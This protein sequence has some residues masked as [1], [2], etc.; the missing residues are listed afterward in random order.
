MN[1]ENQ[2]PFKAIIIGGGASGLM[3]SINLANKFGGDRIL[4]L[5]K[6]D[7][8]GKKLLSTGNGRCNLSNVD[9]DYN[10]Y[11]SQNDGYFNQ[12]IA[13][14]S[15]KV[16][17]F[18]NSI[19]V[20][21]SVEDGKVFPLSKQASSVLDAMRFKLESIGVKTLTSTSVNR[22]KKYDKIFTVFDENGREFYGENVI[23]SVGGKCQ[24]H[25]GTDGSSYSLL[26]EF[27]HKLT[28][29]YPSIVQLKVKDLLRIKGLKGLKQ[30]VDAKAVV[31]GKVV[32]KTQGDLLFTDYGL[33]GNVAFYLS[34]YLTGIKGGVIEIDFCP[35]L[36]REE[37]TRLLIEKQ[38]NCSYLNGEYLLSG[39]MNLKISQSLLR[40]ESVGNLQNPITKFDVSK[41]VDAVKNYKI[42]ISG[43]M[44]FDVAQ[45]TK[46]G[47]CV[48]DFNP[49]TLESKFASGLYATGEVLD[50]DGDC[51]GYNLNW[52]F[53]SALAVSNSIL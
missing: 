39:I 38:N 27:N 1:R 30:K 33:S 23:V 11:H 3:L 37:L 53:C 9:N 49:L 44:G 21:F 24:K 34:S 18:F 8:V 26:T 47:I 45:V 2:R 12:I 5:E 46:G 40:N 7:R 36:T 31:N 19:G 10:H 35:E 42:E 50:V 15:N 16:P 32:S 22:V 52:A 25:L 14:Y 43:T 20:P 28:N 48:Q 17:K 41:V 13:E 4:L 6:L 29:L 51:G